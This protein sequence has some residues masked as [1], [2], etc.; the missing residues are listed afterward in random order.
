V[1]DRSP[2][3][4]HIEQFVLSCRILGLDVEHAAV[5]EIAR[6]SFESGISTL[7][8]TLVETGKNGPCQDVFS[9][10]GFTSVVTDPTLWSLQSIQGM[11]PPSGWASVEWS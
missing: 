10:C 3:L 2:T 11:N 9:R 7:T 5:A 6:R 8:A 4:V 1:V